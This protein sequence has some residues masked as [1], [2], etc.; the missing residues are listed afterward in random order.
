MRN[1]I[2]R[3]KMKAIENW[4]SRRRRLRPSAKCLAHYFMLLDTTALR[5]WVIFAYDKLAPLK[6]TIFP[7][8]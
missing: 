4:R 1:M 8:P 2:D 3:R 6:S 5:A 7:V